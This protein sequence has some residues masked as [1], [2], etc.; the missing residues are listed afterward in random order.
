MF[1]LDIADFPDSAGL[2]VKMAIIAMFL[3]GIMI[4][5]AWGISWLLNT[6]G[7]G[8]VEEEDLPDIDE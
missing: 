4:L 5:V 6:M 8:L 1:E 3:L 2:T 7:S